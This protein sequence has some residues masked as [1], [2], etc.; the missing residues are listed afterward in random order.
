[1]PHLRSKP[2]RL[3][4][5]GPLPPPL[6]GQSQYNSVLRKRFQEQIEVIW[7]D[8]GKTAASKLS[9]AIINPLRVLTQ[10]RRTETV[11]TSAP[12]QMGLWLFLPVIAA[13]RV[14]GIVHF[15]HHHSFRSVNLAPMASHKWLARI[16]GAKS[17]HVLL[18]D[19]MLQRYSDAYLSD[20]QRAGA[21]TVPNAFLFAQE[22]PPSP[23]REGPVTI[24]H[25]SVM[26]R[27]KGVD[28]ILGLIERLLPKTD[29]RFVLGGPVKDED[30][31]AEVEA[32]VAT[33]PD[34]VEWLG[35]VQ[36]E[37]KSAFYAR[38]DLL[39]LPSKLIDEADPLVLLE[40]FA[41][42]T[43][44]LASNR[45][46]IPDRVMSP[47]HLMEMEP[48]ADTSRLKMMAEAI[49]ADRPGWAHRCQDHARTLFAA[50]AAQG[51]ALL[52]ALGLD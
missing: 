33:H 18:S 48:V 31:R 52:S 34:R 32:M 6:S 8:T 23:S 15:V 24:G 10:V 11:Y 3:W 14:R 9:S 47:D 39:L 45:G 16:G 50:A 37:A 27:E 21:L 19:S 41:A 44:T 17:R 40:A 42:G 49:A 28:Y 35:L 26:T 46:C 43:A 38:C 1:M 29:Y 30:L 4:C 20:A 51:N 25:L 13:L 36:G 2:L 7:L 5:I 22:I 12:G